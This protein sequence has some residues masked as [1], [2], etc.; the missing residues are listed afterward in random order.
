[1][2]IRRALIIPAI[3]ALGV[4]SSALSGSAMAA[5]TGHASSVQVQATAVASAHPGIYYHI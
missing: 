4:A 5:A 2:R 3:L 1:M